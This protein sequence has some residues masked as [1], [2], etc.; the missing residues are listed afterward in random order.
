M[1]ETE[2]ARIRGIIERGDKIRCTS[3]EELVG[4]REALRGMVVH[5]WCLHD[6]ACTPSECRCQPEY[7]IERLTPETYLAGQD[8]Q[9][10]WVKE[11]SS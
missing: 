6:D 10:Q 9:A 4:I 2:I 5:A 7:I 11:K 3:M 8:A 1:T